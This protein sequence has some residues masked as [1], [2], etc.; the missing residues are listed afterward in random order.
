MELKRIKHYI[1]RSLQVGPLTTC[2]LLHNRAKTKFFNAYWRKKALK[3][4]ASHVWKDIL[5]RHYKK[6]YQEFGNFWNYQLKN[7]ELPLEDLKLSLDKEALIKEADGYVDKYFSILGSSK[8]KYNSIPWHCDIRLQEMDSVADVLFDSQAFYK[9]ITITPGKEKFAKDIKVP[10]ELSRLQHFFVLGYAYKQTY[11]DKYVNAFIEHYTDWMN[12]NHFLLGPNWVCPMDVGIRALNII[13]ALSLFKESSALLQDFLQKV[14]ASL[15]DHLFYLEHNWELYDSRTSNHYLSDLVGYQYLTYFFYDLPGISQKALWCNQEIQKEFEKQVFDEGADYEGS[16]SYHCLVTELFFHHYL[17]ADQMN[18]D[19]D[20]AYVSKLKRMF[21]FIDWCKPAQQSSMITI[22]DRDSGKILHYGISEKLIESMKYHEVI[23]RKDFKEFGISIVKTD[24]VHFSLRHNV[25]NMRQPSG[26][27]HNDAAAITLAIQGINIFIDPG[28]YL[29]TPSIQ[30]RNQFRSVRSHST[31][32][33]RDTEPVL[34]DDR[35][36]YLALEQQQF[37]P[38]WNDSNPLLVKTS[39]TLYR[40]QL[41]LTALRSVEYIPSAKELRI[42]DIW[43]TDHT[44]DP[45]LYGCWNFTLSPSISV[46]KFNDLFV[47]KHQ[48][49]EIALF[50]SMLNFEQEPI[51]ISL[52]YGEQVPTTKLC[53]SVNLM[54][55]DPVITTIKLL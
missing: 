1:H 49:K 12:N 2:S 26:H 44:L 34:L 14:V 8:K 54:H 11:D 43:K 5:K 19:L 21:D 33:I 42:I 7:L 9:E 35:L 16:T 36:F 29:Y 22:G 40:K 3:K 37:L 51:M 52:E 55:N 28:S 27:F 50:E 24:A 53:A 48:G 38:E 47:I 18:F 32:C 13:W 4:Q 45:E 20:D 39:H 46:E 10:W 30:V 41:R 31:F 15:Y 6:K 17:I 25:Y 23:P